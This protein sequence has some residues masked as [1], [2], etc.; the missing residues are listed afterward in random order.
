VQIGD[1][2]DLRHASFRGVRWTQ[3][4]LQ[5]C[6]LEGADFSTAKL[7]SANLSHADCRGANFRG[8]TLTRAFMPFAD[9]RGADL[10]GATL[11]S[12]TLG[13]VRVDESTRLDG[14]W[15]DADSPLLPFAHRNA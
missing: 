13:S 7:I 10:S 9:L 8:A 3:A 11:T 1:Y 2:D 4:I 12:A 6:L 5:G 15:L 14:A